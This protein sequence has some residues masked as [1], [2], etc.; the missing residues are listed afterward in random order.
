MNK[1][2]FVNKKTHSF[3]TMPWYGW[4]CAVITIVLHVG[5]YKLAFCINANCR[6]WDGF[7]PAISVIDG[8]IPFVPWFWIQ[9]YILSYA[10]WFVAPLIISKYDRQNLID[11]MIGLSIASFA[12]FFFM[13]FVPTWMGR[14]DEVLNKINNLKDPFTKFCMKFMYGADSIKVVV[15]GKTYDA[16]FNLAPSFHCLFSIYAFL[17]IHRAKK[18]PFYHKIWIGVYAY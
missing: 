16:S 18:A 1:N 8:N 9:V 15:D 5:L 6:I 4:I 10:F 17:G 3:L 12:G 7:N 2:F 14:S 11:F 13:I